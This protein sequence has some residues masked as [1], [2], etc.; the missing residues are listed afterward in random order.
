[1]AFSIPEDVV[2]KVR[3]SADIVEV[4][5]DHL[6]LRPAGRNFK[7]LCPFHAEK[8]PSFM[9]SPEKQ[10]YHCFGCGAGGNVFNFLMQFENITFPEAVRT[11][12]KRYGIQ[13]PKQA[14]GRS[15]ESDL[16]Y[17][18]NAFAARA[19]RAALL[20]T[21][22]GTKARTYLRSRDISEK[23][24]E[25]F[26]LGYA[27]SQGD[28]L[29]QQARQKNLSAER[30]RLLG[31][32]IEK[33]G[34]TTD[35][36]KRR[37]MF[38]IASPGSRVVGF[39]GRVLDA[40]QP[41]YLNSPETQLFKKSQTLYGI[42]AAKGAIRG[43]GG[44][45]V[46]E[47]YMDVIPLHA[48]GLRQTVAS[49]GTAFT[50]D[51]AR[52]LKRY[53]GDAVFLYDGDDAGLLAALRACAPA[54]QAGLKTSVALL[55]DGE[56]PDSF[57]RARG[58][59]A[60]EDLVGKALHYVDFI[61]AQAPA[62]DP[63]EGIR[64]AL[65]VISRISDPVRASLDLKRLSERCGIPEV[66][67]ERSLRNIPR[68]RR[69]ESD[70]KP[71]DTIACDMIEK[72]IVSILIGLPDSA[73]SVFREISPSDFADHRMRTIAQAILDRKSKSLAF[74]ASALLTAIDDEPTRN[75][76]IDCSVAGVVHGDA[77]RIIADHITSMKRKV[78]TRQI[79]QLR[80][81]IQVAE[82][83]GDADRLQDLLAKRQS[84]AE[85]LRL[86]ST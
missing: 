60:V 41:K 75:L 52:N 57:L 51:Q 36:F 56:D 10:I 76:L 40:S 17:R 65:S 8:T 80:R 61:M 72:S 64:Y 14:A 86:L 16:A 83:E 7:G 66:T 19:F 20:G 25:E 69:S 82:K 49:L 5:S 9:V 33:D 15:S 32:A 81:Q 53:C 1:M 27:P 18:I 68:E 54:V 3:E 59:A 62:D 29:V 24:E 46:T 22:E 11:L 48:Q 38:P 35:L 79:A 4:V 55:P 23:T 47:G 12:A 63:E 58:R 31:L 67:L 39:G 84:L 77:G 13:V 45:I 74:D 78:I 70:R 43:G 2:E 50:F 73:E 34:R 44:A 21:K 85:T 30:L 37:L 71:A 42:H 26:L 28:F 6:A